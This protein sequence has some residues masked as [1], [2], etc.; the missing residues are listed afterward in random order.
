MI[1]PPPRSTLF[2][3]PALSRSSGKTE[4]L[5]T[6]TSSAPPP[7][8]RTQATRSPSANPE[9]DGARSEEHTS[10][11]QS[12]NISYAVFCL[13]KKP[14]LLFCP[15]LRPLAIVAAHVISPF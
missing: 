13:K 11:L 5:C 6:A 3:Y 8:G 9:P 1:R 7:Y 10:E 14:L 4:S 15:P 12:A 2:P